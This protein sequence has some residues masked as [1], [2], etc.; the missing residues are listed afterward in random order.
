MTNLVENALQSMSPTRR[1][2]AAAIHHDAPVRPPR[3]RSLVRSLLQGDALKADVKRFFRTRQDSLPSSWEVDSVVEIERSLAREPG[4]K[5]GGYL[6]LLR[7]TCDLFEASRKET[8]WTENRLWALI[9]RRLSSSSGLMLLRSVANAHEIMES[10]IDDP[11]DARRRGFCDLLRVIGARTGQILLEHPRLIDRSIWEFTL[12]LTVRADQF[13][14]ELRQVSGRVIRPMDLYFG[15]ISVY[16]RER[17]TEPVLSELRS[18]VL[19]TGS[20]LGPALEV[21]VRQLHLSPGVA[22]IPGL[23]IPDDPRIW[24]W[25]TGASLR[26]QDG[27]SDRVGRLASCERA[28]LERSRAFEA[29]KDDVA[30]AIEAE[31]RKKIAESLPESRRIPASVELGSKQSAGTTKTDQKF[32][33]G[34]SSVMDIQTAIHSFGSGSWGL[35]SETSE[36]IPN[37]GFGVPDLERQARWIAEGWKTGWTPT[38]RVWAEKYRTLLGD[39]RVREFLRLGP[40]WIAGL[41]NLLTEADPLLMAGW[42]DLIRW[43]YPAKFRP[44]QIEFR[45]NERPGSSAHRTGYDWTVL[46]L[47]ALTLAEVASAAREPGL[48]PS[49]LVVVRHW[50]Q[51]SRASHLA[52][53]S[54][55]WWSWLTEEVDQRAEAEGDRQFPSKVELDEEWKVRYVIP[56]IAFPSPISAAILGDWVRDPREAILND[57]RLVHERWA[58]RLS[59]LTQMQDEA[60]EEALFDLCSRL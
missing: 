11:D 48:A 53:L 44:D 59:M 52:P 6:G 43:I 4:Y 39:S 7:Y 47:L 29:W 38:G 13:N 19:Q 21:W 1:A 8:T 34:S 5:E 26:Q 54:Q 45:Q 23:Q 60:K 2:P 31:L 16:L 50:Q 9:R 35:L 51:L 14:S 25:E 40:S 37:I 33:P 36:G 46:R 22:F 49:C 3:N 10:L 15:S 57:T 20:P 55:E 42:E 58:S 17:G 41:R 30:M 24:I 28:I 32:D 27:L 18:A 12:L 56:W